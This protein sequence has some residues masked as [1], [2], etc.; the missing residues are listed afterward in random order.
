MKL[1]P[2]YVLGLLKKYSLYTTQ[3]TK[4]TINLDEFDLQITTKSF[5]WPKISTYLKKRLTFI[6]FL[7]LL[8]TVLMLFSSRIFNYLRQIAKTS[9]NEQIAFLKSSNKERKALIESLNVHEKILRSDIKSFKTTMRSR[10]TL[11]NRVFNAQNKL[12]PF[13]AYC[14]SEAKADKQEKYAKLFAKLNNS[15]NL[16]EVSGEI[17]SITIEHMI[18]NVIDISAVD[19][20]H[21]RIIISTEYENPEK[22]RCDSVKLQ[23]ILYNMLKTL[24]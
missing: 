15:L 10:A 16:C 5:T 17:E 20:N 6:L 2:G 11:V 24:N 8:Y 18:Q 9:V 13:I 14:L 12:G 4:D 23:L 21:R 1:M 7:L 22:I 3:K 19:L